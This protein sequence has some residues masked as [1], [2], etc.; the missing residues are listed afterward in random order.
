MTKTKDL[1]ERV[2]NNKRTGVPCWRQ[3]AKGKDLLAFLAEVEE[4]IERGEIPSWRH[5]A[6]VL[7]SEFDLKI[8]GIQVGRHYRQECRCGR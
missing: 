4:R 6:A 3:R 5:L 8:G 1:V 2:Y 7:T